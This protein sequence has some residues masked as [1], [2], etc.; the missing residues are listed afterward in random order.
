MT[1]YLTSLLVAIV[2]TILV[3]L[4]PALIALMVVG[5]I[6]LAFIFAVVMWI[7]LILMALKQ[8]GMALVGKLRL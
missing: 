5:G 8:T 4:A 7:Y 1:D 2:G 6:T 3:I